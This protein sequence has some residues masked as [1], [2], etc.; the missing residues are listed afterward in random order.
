MKPKTLVILLI[1]LGVLAGAG[2][3]L[4]HSRDARSPSGEMGMRLFEDLPVNDVA[5]IDI[6]TPTAAVS[7]KKTAEAWMVKERFG[8]PADFAK[9]SDLVRTLREVK[10][11]RRFDASDE[12]VRRLALMPPDAAD[13]GEGERGTRVRMRDPD[14]KPILDM[15]LGKTRTRD[16]QKGPPDG[17]YVM[18]GSGSDIFL[19]D[20]ILSSFESGP[21]QWLQK[22]PVQVDDEEVR[23]IACLGPD[24][25]TVRYAMERPARGKDF[26]WMSPPTDHHVKKSSLNRLTRA[27]SGLQIEDV[28]PASKASEMGKGGDAFRVDY[29]LFDGRIYRV[30]VLTGCSPTVPCRIRIEAACGA[31]ESQEADA[32]QGDRSKREGSAG[33]DGEEKPSPPAEEAAQEDARL[34]PWVFTIPEWQYQAFFTDPEALLEKEAEK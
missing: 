26:Q 34:R 18:S 6:Q 3:L 12:V 4:M 32:D 28:E 22:S 7:L 1:I 15:V 19:I 25:T 10:I 13:A 5:F 9:L 29:T 8:Y 11:G 30:F 20:R 17:Q 24:G 27:L 16:P 2:V 33:S 21:A 23:R 14:G 31:P